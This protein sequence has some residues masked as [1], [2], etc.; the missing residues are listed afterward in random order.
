MELE[1]TEKK[2][3]YNVFSNLHFNFEQ[4]LEWIENFDG[5]FGYISMAEYIR[6][7]EMLSFDRQSKDQIL[8][9]AFDKMDYGNYENFFRMSYNINELYQK[10]FLVI[11]IEY[12][13]DYLKK[14][15]FIVWEV[16]ARYYMEEHIRIQP[17]DLSLDD[18][19]YEPT[20]KHRIFKFFKSKKIDLQQKLDFYTKNPTLFSMIMEYFQKK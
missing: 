7:V 12:V 6:I 9:K 4:C 8:N 13:T 2:K 3:V 14:P 20:S 10:I 15:S 19:G 16:V 17:Y 11:M 1:N 5:K 18:M